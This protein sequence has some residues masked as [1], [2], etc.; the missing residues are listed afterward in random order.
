MSR[1]VADPYQ[2]KR[3]FS[4]EQAADYCGVSVYKVAIA[5]RENLLAARRNG[6]DIVIF[7]EDLDAWMEGWEVI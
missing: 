2:W 4:R 7:R 3:G 5:I 6:K 1:E